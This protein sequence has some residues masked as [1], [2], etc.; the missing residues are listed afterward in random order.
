MKRTRTPLVMIL[1]AGFALHVGGALSCGGEDIGE[2]DC[3]D[4]VDNDGDGDTDCRD[5]DCA[6]KAICQGC[7]N[8]IKDGDEECDGQDFGSEFCETRGY[9][10]GWLACNPDCTI[11]ESACEPAVCGDNIANGGEECDGYDMGSH[12]S[13]EEQG[14]LGGIVMCDDESCTYDTS[15][16]FNE[17]TCSDVDIA[18]PETPWCEG[19][20]NGSGYVWVYYEWVDLDDGKDYLLQLELFS[21]SQSFSLG[22]HDLAAADSYDSCPVCALLIQCADPNC[23]YAGKRFLPTAG[24]LNLTGID[25]ANAGDITGTLSNVSWKEVEIDWGQT[26]ESTPI[27]AGPCMDLQTPHSLDASVLQPQP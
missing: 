5:S 16:C 24:T 10:G 21:Q 6:G 8:G 25:V 15:Q 14:F 9:I 11:D 23:Q 3:L 20:P 7:G 17:V 22:N 13:C 27:P 26:W 4:G 19:Q 18:S 1:A 2:K 12:A